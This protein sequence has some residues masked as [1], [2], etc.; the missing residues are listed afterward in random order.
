MNCHLNM[1]KECKSQYVMKIIVLASKDKMVA[2]MEL[3]PE[4]TF[5]IAKIYRYIVTPEVSKHRIFIWMDTAIIPNHMSLSSL[6]TMI[7][8][9]EFYI[10]KF[11]NL[12]SLR[13]RH[14]TL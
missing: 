2:C 12:W 14:S 5:S 13:T 4:Y 7:I 3:R 6:E 10:Q 8:S 1:Y 9:L 11:M